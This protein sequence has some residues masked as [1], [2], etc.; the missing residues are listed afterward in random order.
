MAITQVR[1][2]NAGSTGSGSS[3]AFSFTALP[4]VGNLIVVSNSIWNAT[5]GDVASVTGNHGN[6]AAILASR[7]G[8]GNK[9]RSLIYYFPNIRP[10]SG[11]HTITVTAS[12][13]STA[14]EAI[15]TEVN[16]TL[17]PLTR[18]QLVT[19]QQTSTSTNP[20]T[21]NSPTTTD[22]EEYVLATASV[23][24]GS[25]TLGFTSPAG[26]TNDYV[27][28]NSSGTVGAS[29]DHLIVATTG[30]Q[31]AAWTISHT[32]QLGWAC[33]LATFATI[34]AGGTAD[35]RYRFRPSVLWSGTS[36]LGTKRSTWP[37]DAQDLKR[38][39]AI[40]DN[41]SRGF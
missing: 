39:D 19:A 4:A 1:K 37:D 13:A 16:S 14:I 23:D 7:S 17:G 28:N 10:S 5:G 9:A 20:A 11:T 29:M 34:K 35:D 38:R 18:D 32:S 12:G 27:Q 41:L 22:P 15:A 40:N 30:V 26:Y 6:P 8:L 31:S 2:S 25:T 21:G 3:I 33:A 24:S 36:T